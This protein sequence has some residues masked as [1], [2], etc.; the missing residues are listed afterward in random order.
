[1]FDK[2][3][4]FI[5]KYVENANVS[6]NVRN[7]CSGRVNGGFLAALF[8]RPAFLA[9]VGFVTDL[10]PGHLSCVVDTNAL[11]VLND[12]QPFCT[13]RLKVGEMVDTRPN[14]LGS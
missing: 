13:V 10:P 11:A 4:A 1:M 8:R 7:M 5:T 2:L 6:L 3:R 9:L 14:I 12:K